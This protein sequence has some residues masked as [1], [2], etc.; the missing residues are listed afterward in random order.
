MPQKEGEFIMINTAAIKRTTNILFSRDYETALQK[1]NEEGRV[2]LLSPK[3]DFSADVSIT[4]KNNETIEIITLNEGGKSTTISF[5]GLIFET[6]PLSIR[7]CSPIAVGEETVN[8]I[9]S[10]STKKGYEVNG[11][12]ETTALSEESAT[13]HTSAIRLYIQKA[14]LKILAD[15]N[16]PFAYI[17]GQEASFYNRGNLTKQSSST[18]RLRCEEETLC[19][20]KRMYELLREATRAKNYDYELIGELIET[21]EALEQRQAQEFYNSHKAILVR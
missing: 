15:Q 6:K 16:L 21:I 10:L 18:I 12:T 2:T 13:R 20:L 19:L 11:I 17:D 5:S 1:R 14:Q 4:H 3:I 9:T 7:T 8:I